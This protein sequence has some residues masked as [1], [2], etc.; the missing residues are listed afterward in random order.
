MLRLQSILRSE[1]DRI[2]ERV[3][4]SLNLNIAENIGGSLGVATRVG[5]LEVVADL[6]AR[7]QL[8]KLPRLPV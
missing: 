4:V 3:Q 7:G 6:V 1:D 8:A 2:N 5:E